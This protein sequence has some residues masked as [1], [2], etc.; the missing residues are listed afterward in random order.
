ML[1]LDTSLL[2]AVLSNEASTERIQ[3]WLA[4]QDP[5]RLAISDWTMTEI[6]SALAV[7]LRTG[8]IDLDMRAMA[9][10]LFNRMVEES[11]TVLAVTA[12]HF[13]AAARFV[14]HHALGLR[15]GD[16]LHLAVAAQY[17]ATVCTLDVRM[18]AAGPV[19]GVPALLLA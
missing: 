6:S 11:F 8:A 13:R 1:Y 18:A 19:L 16:A 5:D 10:A 14:D 4:D 17:G 15:A 12:A 2:F 9:L 7:K 3:A